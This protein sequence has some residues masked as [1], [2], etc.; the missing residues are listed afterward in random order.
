MPRAPAPTDE[1]VTS[2]PSVSPASTVSGAVQC[3]RA[4][5]WRSLIRRISGRASTAE[6][7]NS[8]AT[9]SVIVISR[10]ELSPVTPSRYSAAIVATEPGML[11][12]ASSPVIRQSTVPRRPWVRL[13]TL[14]VAA[15]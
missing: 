13:P 7:L 4:A 9:P 15:A 10:G 5:A 14:L 8:S 12:A 3:R 2:I 6:A 11:P 1:I